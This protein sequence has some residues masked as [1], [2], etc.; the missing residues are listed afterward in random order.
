LKSFVTDANVLF[1]CLISG[2]ADYIDLFEKYQFYLPDFAL[3]ELQFYQN[4]IHLKTKLAPQSLQTF[5]LGMFEK[6]I[7]VP[8]LLISTQNYLQAFHLCK[9][10]DEKDTVYVA[11]SIEL[12]MPLLTRDK[13]LIEGL[14]QKGFS[15]VLSFTDF[16]NKTN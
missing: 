16:M 10:I 2:K 5:T 7:V 14:I 6:I 15:N 8:N 4:L 9:D 1:S 3:T 13:Q 11:L 12:D